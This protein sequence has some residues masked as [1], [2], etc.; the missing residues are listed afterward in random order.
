[1]KA[2]SSPIVRQFL[3][4]LSRQ[5]RWKQDY[6]R[7]LAYAKGELA[8]ATDATA[9]LERLTAEAECGRHFDGA[10]GFDEA[11]LFVTS[12]AYCERALNTAISSTDESAAR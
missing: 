8:K 7:G 11:I 2:L 1:V 4:I 12:E 5:E 3:G 6:E 10:N 9:T